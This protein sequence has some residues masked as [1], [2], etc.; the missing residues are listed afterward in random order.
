MQ[1][2]KSCFAKYIAIGIEEHSI[3]FIAA[4]DQVDTAPAAQAHGF[5]CRR[6]RSF[7]TQGADL[8]PVNVQ[9][10]GLLRSVFDR[11]LETWNRRPV[12]IFRPDPADPR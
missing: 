9:L 6:P 12:A 8:Q 7:E 11:N 3:D 4:I 2:G 10:D 1:S 5:C